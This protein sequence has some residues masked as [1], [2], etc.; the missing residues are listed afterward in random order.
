MRSFTQTLTCALLALIACTVVA[1]SKESLLIGPGDL[2]Q[3]K[4]LDT[5]ELDQTV[6]VTDAGMIPLIVGG[7]VNV[8]SQTPEAAARQIESAL[9]DRHFLLHPHVSVK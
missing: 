8:S 5:P 2:L 6:R 4:V 1:Q 9:F 3:V 7:D